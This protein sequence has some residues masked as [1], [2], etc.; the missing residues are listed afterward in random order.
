[1]EEDFEKDLRERKTSR[2]Q[3]GRYLKNTEKVLANPAIEEENDNSV[4]IKNEEE[5]KKDSE[6]I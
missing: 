4:E 1:M 2:I 3:L 5:K 6:V